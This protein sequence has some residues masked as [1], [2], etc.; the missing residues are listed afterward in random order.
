M[1]QTGPTQTSLGYQ[2]G[3]LVTVIFEAIGVEGNTCHDASNTRVSIQHIRPIANDEQRIVPFRTQSHQ[4]Q[5]FISAHTL[6]EARS[7]FVEWSISMKCHSIFL[8]VRSI[9]REFLAGL[10]I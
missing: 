5:Q 6:L 10:Y 2:E 9:H 1:Q 3:S 4:T 8:S 7:E